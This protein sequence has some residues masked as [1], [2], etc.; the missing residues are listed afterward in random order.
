MSLDAVSVGKA[1]AYLRKKLD[2]HRENS[3]KE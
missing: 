1:I 3:R 2:T